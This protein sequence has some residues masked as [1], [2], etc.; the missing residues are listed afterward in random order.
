MGATTQRLRLPLQ[1]AL[2][3][4]PLFLL[5]PELLHRKDFSRRDLLIVCYAFTPSIISFWL[6]MVLQ[7]W[8]AFGNQ[9]PAIVRRVEFLL[10]QAI[11]RV[12]CGQQDIAGSMT[13]FISE[14][15]W[16]EL[17]KIKI[18]DAERK[19]FQTKGTR[20]YLVFIPACPYHAVELDG[21]EHPK[22]DRIQ[23]EGSLP[24]GWPLVLRGAFG[25]GCGSG[26]GVRAQTSATPLP[27]NRGSFA[28]RG[29]L[30]LRGPLTS[31]EAADPRADDI[32]NDGT[33]GGGSGALPRS[34][35]SA[36]G[37][38][39]AS[40][41]PNSISMDISHDQDQSFRSGSVNRALSTLPGSDSPLSSP[42]ANSDG[43]EGEGE[44][45][46][47]GEDGG[48]WGPKKRKALRDDSSDEEHSDSRP[49][50]KPGG[51][52]QDRGSSGTKKRKTRHDGDLSDEEDDGSRPSPGTKKMR[53][54]V[55]AFKPVSKVKKSRKMS[56]RRPELK[57]RQNLRNEGEEG[58]T[59]WRPIY[60]SVRI[61]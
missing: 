22:V 2:C 49:E 42:F 37:N 44:G 1:L 58:D 33:E 21:S 43:S 57:P 5:V 38:L 45:R 32:A 27:S 53:Y 12:A 14:V 8:I 29:N 48:S 9:A 11:L 3:V 47:G 17:R 35:K 15:P 51:E 52:N 61:F 19:W 31:E 20:M 28:L 25:G 39:L 16:P 54:R 13:A 10:W 55:I 26:E 23:I 4:S 46:S 59:I 6:I 24:E 60:I 34:V 36:Q 18:E 50:D 56:P 41:P 30:T 40:P 7:T